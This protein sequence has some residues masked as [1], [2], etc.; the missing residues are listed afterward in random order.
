MDLGSGKMLG[1]KALKGKPIFRHFGS[2]VRIYREFCCGP[3]V[4]TS[5]NVDYAILLLNGRKETE[6]H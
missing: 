4:Q 5:Q 2:S 3:A 6:A 1:A